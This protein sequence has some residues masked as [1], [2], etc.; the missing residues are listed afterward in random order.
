MEQQP[1]ISICIPAYNRPQYLKR[2]LDS[3]AIQSFTSFEV[4]VTDDSPGNEV[5]TFLQQLTV[6]FALQYVKNSKPL[7]TPA[8]WMEGIK[9]ANSTWIKIMHDDDWFANEDSLQKFANAISG[10]VDCIFSGYNAFY[11]ASGTEVDKTIT[12]KQFNRIKAYPYYLFGDN[13]IGP[14]SVAMFRKEISE[15]YDTTLK[16]LVDLEGYVRMLKKYN[17]VYVAAPAIVM[18]YNDSQVTNDCFRN[19]DVEI[20]EALI[21]YKKNGDVVRKKL[22]AYDAWWRMLRNLN[23]RSED[24]LNHYAK[25][26]VVPPFLKRILSFQK[27]IPAVVLKQ[28]VCSKLLMSVSYFLNR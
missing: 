14:P 26:E 22:L 17:C 10:E 24:Q 20:R 18:S 4:I 5:E 8:N 2:L 11:E 16:W 12:Q 6:S 27:F 19:P 15:L 28:G 7:G 3:I 25:G 21:Y 9:Y 1:L 13:V 23:I